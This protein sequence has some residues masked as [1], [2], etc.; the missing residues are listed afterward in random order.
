[1]KIRKTRRINRGG[2]FAHLTQHF[3]DMVAVILFRNDI[4]PYRFHFN[5]CG[6]RYLILVWIL[7]GQSVGCAYCPS[8]QGWCQEWHSYPPFIDMACVHLRELAFWSNSLL[9]NSW[10][11]KRILCVCH[12]SLGTRTKVPRNAFA[13]LMDS[14]QCGIF[15]L[16]R[17]AFHNKQRMAWIFCWDKFTFHLWRLQDICLLSD[18]LQPSTPDVET[19][20]IF[21]HFLVE[22]SLPGPGSNRLF[23]VSVA[24]WR[25]IQLAGG[26]FAS[27]PLFCCESSWICRASESDMKMNSFER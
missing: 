12:L 5:F 21:R 18:M 4:F 15:H 7:S 19:N 25:H 11:G 20:I 3:V 26:C 17:G 23:R 27:A 22:D 6:E 24:S 8:V 2:C 16:K 1:M 13:F 10:C 14:F 9:L